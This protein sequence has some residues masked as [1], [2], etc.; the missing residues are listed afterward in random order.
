LDRLF[1]TRDV[2]PR[3]RLSFW[4]DV[5]CKAFV[6]IEC[7]TDAGPAFDATIWSRSLSGISISLVDSDQCGVFRRRRAIARAASDDVLLSLQLAG[8]SLLTQN[9]R[10]TRLGAGDFAIYDTMRTYALMVPSGVRQLVLKLPRREL[11]RRL[12]SI[13]KYTAVAIRADDPFGAFASGFLG[14]IP[15]RADA[16]D[17]L[18]D[19]GAD[20]LSGKIYDMVALAFRNGMD[21]DAAARTPSREITLA[22]LKAAIEERLWDPGLKPGAAAAAGIG[23]RYANELLSGEGSLLEPF[24]LARRLTNCAEALGDRRQSG[25][26]ISDIA[27]AWGFADVSHFGR[28]FK[29]RYGCTPRDYRAARSKA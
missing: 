28:R 11:E 24:I 16:L 29:E 7:R 20:D 3:D 25:R 8:S 12:G 5:A 21:A 19:R 6:E 23:A 26:P 4:Q 15:A 17:R 14:L 1:S 13:S 9:G 22:R 10:E 18:D 2:H 27:F